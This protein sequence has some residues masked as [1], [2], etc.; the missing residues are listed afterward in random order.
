N[1]PL[2]A[3]ERFRKQVALVDLVGEMDP[4]VIAKAVWS[5]YQ[6]K[7]TRFL[8]YT[9]FDPGAY[10]EEPISCRLSWRVKHP[11][12]IEEWELE[13]LAKGIEK[14]EE[15]KV[16]PKEKEEVVEVSE[17]RIAAI[18]RHL[19]RIAEEL[20]QIAEILL[21]E[22]PMVEEVKPVPLVEEAPVVVAPVV[23]GFTEEELY[24]HNQLRTYPGVL[25]GLAA[26][27]KDI[28]HVGLSLPTTVNKLIKML[29]KLKKSLEGSSLPEQ[30][31]AEFLS[32][33]DGFL[34]VAE[35]LP[36]DPGPCQ[37]TA[38]TCTIG[39]GCLVTGVIDLLKLATEPAAP[40]Q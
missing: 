36:T 38:G 16:I 34:N 11:E 20:S 14:K 22:A 31:K 17:Y 29:G 2:E 24:F 12:A 32:K 13:D 28:C 15:V 7:P 23:A 4:A 6:E 21:E 37:K 33:I 30:R 39:K 25:V 3:I 10:A 19:S 27:D 40:T 9:L 5:C 1:I 8:S 18:G 26:C 35:G